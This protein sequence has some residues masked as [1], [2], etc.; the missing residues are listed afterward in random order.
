MHKS[1]NL[2]DITVGDFWGF[3]KESMPRGFSPNLGT[4]VVI[5]NTETGD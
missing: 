4:N 2:S 3:K 5:I 1:N